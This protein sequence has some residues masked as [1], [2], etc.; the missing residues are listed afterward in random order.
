MDREQVEGY[1]ERQ[2]ATMAIVD[3]FV[4]EG[5]EQGINISEECR[6]RVLESAVTRFGSEGGLVCFFSFFFAYID[7]GRA[8]LL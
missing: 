5:A 8:V 6:A 4:A 1:F 7:G 3:R 2:A